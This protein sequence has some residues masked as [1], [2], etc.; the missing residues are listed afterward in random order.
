VQNSFGR[1]RHS[2]LFFLFTELVTK[3]CIDGTVHFISCQYWH[4]KSWDGTCTNRKCEYRSKNCP[5]CVIK[6]FWLRFQFPLQYAHANDIRMYRTLFYDHR[7][8]CFA[9]LLHRAT[10]S[11]LL[12]TNVPMYQNIISVIMFVNVCTLKLQPST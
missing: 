9:S 5:V 10:Y 8:S 7:I 12:K 1:S 2:C 3:N 4:E 6:H 11:K